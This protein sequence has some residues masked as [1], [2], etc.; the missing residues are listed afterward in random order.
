MRGLGLVLLTCLALSAC[1]SPRQTTGTAVGVAAGAL[2]AGPV[3]A[4]AGG[5]VG[6]AVTAPSYCYVP[7][8]YGRMRRRVC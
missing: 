6:A 5:A 1:S 3:G 2:V 7:D 4:V 8:R